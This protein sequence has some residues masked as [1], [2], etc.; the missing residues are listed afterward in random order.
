MDGAGNEATT[1]KRTDGTAATFRLPVRIDT[2]LAVGVRSR[3]TR[4]LDPD[5]LA[6]LGRRIRLTGRLSNA[7]GQ[8]LDGATIEAIEKRPDGSMLPTGL[9]TTNEYGG[10]RYLLRARRNRELIFRY[11]GSRRIGAATAKFRLRVPGTTSIRVSRRKIRNGQSVRFTGQV[12]TRPV[13]TNGKLIEM[14]A[15]F[16]GRWRTFATLRTD[17]RGT[18]R[19][20]YRFGAT[21][22]RV[23]YRFRAQLPY[24]GGYPFVTG[25]SRVARVVVVGP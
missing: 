20:R 19:F 23:T 1:G 9:T 11:P 10:F 16:R 21:L 22:G 2:R 12:L 3:R 4:R 6:P 8:P 14:Q 5:V 13:P 17:R 15:Y 18:W 7:D 25:H 24:E